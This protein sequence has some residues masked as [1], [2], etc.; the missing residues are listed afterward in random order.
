MRLGDNNTRAALDVRVCVVL[1]GTARCEL[2]CGAA[3][4]HIN[5]AYS[6]LHEPRMRTVRNPFDRPSV[7]WAQRARQQQRRAETGD[8]HSRLPVTRPS[9]F[10]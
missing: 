9:I 1:H 8:A 6:L 7:L 4:D 5:A 10:S 3:P 2:T